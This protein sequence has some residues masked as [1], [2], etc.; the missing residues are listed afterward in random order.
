VAD[1]SSRPRDDV[2]EDV[3]EPVPAGALGVPEQRAK[4]DLVAAVLPRAEDVFGALDL[5]PP[6]GDESLEQAREREPERENEA[7]PDSGTS[8]PASAAIRQKRPD[9]QPASSSRVS[10]PIARPATIAS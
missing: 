8:A 10:G 1:P 6:G 5:Q 3:V 9:P 2:A 7:M 4:R